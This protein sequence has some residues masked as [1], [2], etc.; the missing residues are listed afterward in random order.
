MKFGARSAALLNWLLNEAL[1]PFV[2]DSRL[3]WPLFR[4]AFGRQARTFWTFRQ[5]DD[6]SQA[7]LAEV[8]GETADCD[9]KKE[10]DTTGEILQR[11]LR[12]CGAGDTVLD[13]GSGR[14]HT[15]AV[16]Q[17]HGC[18]VAGVDLGRAAPDSLR[19]RYAIARTEA[20]P[21]ATDAF[22]AVLCAHVLEHIPDIF[23]AVQELRRVAR[24]RLIVVLPVERPYLR[25]FN[26]HLWFFPYRLNVVQILRPRSSHWT[27]E[28]V[29]NEWFYVEEIDRD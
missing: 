28:R 22:D 11:I 8:Y 10:S 21:F 16:L 7:W 23:A 15:A 5:Q 12:L 13:A 4:L 3:L 26:L 1:P 2:R 19:G 14:G 20:L 18:R 17:R 9:L 6:Y 27:L 29:G 25:G 24:R